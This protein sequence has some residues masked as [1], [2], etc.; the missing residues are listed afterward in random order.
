[1]TYHCLYTHFLLDLYL[2]LGYLVYQQTSLKVLYLALMPHWYHLYLKEVSDK[3]VLMSQ[4]LAG[5]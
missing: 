4:L 2:I 5:F 3:F 1:M